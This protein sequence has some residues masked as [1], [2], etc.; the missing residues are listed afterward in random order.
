MFLAFLVSYESGGILSIISLMAF[1]SAE[2]VSRKDI[3]GGTKFIIFVCFYI[4]IAVIAAVI[5]E[6]LRTDSEKPIGAV[7]LH[8][9]TILI[10]LKFI[11]FSPLVAPLL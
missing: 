4:I 5:K 10:T 7:Y 3:S 9:L 11:Q 1:L 8:F 6:Q 2:L